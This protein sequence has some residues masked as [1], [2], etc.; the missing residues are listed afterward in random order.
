V[1]ASAGNL[2]LRRLPGLVVSAWGTDVAGEGRRSPLAAW[3]QRF[4][5]AQAAAITATSRFLAGETAKLAPRGARIEVIPF[6][7]DCRAFS[8]P[9]APRPGADG[10]T[11]AFVKHLEPKYGPELLLEAFA[12]IALRRADVRLIMVGNGSARPLLVRQAEELGVAGRVSFPGAIPHEEV[13]S[14]LA[15]ADIFAMPSVCREGFGVAAL[16]ASA[17]AL[18][19][20]ASGTGGIPEAVRDGET[21]LL[22]PAGDPKLLEQALLR[23]IEDGDLRERL[24]RQGRDWV[25]SR[26]TWEDSVSK[27]QQLYRDLSAGGDA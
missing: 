13:P 23:L 15:R 3:L 22:V 14:V 5:L 16:E 17:M 27:M 26:Y 18:P 19:V 1:A 8:P 10:L 25:L 2:A 6:G 12:S 7:V 4:L 24:G 21:G 20:V 11:I 9:A